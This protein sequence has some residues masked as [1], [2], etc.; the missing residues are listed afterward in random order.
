[1][2]AGIRRTVALLFALVPMGLVVA[3]PTAEALPPKLESA[4]ATNGL[5]TANWSL[6]PTVSTQFFEVGKYLEVNAYG[7][8]QCNRAPLPTRCGDEESN[9]VRFGVLAS[10][11][12]SLTPAD[13]T[14]PL[15]AGTYYIHIAGHD[16]VHTACPQVEFSQTR[17]VEIHQDGSATDHGVVAPGT[18]D[19]TL[20]PGAAGSGGGSAGGGGGGG[21]GAVAGDKIPP[22]TQLRYSRRQKLNKLRVRAR[23]SEPGTLT[24]RALVDVGGLLARIYNFRPVSRKVTGGV[25]ATLKPRLS[26]RHKRALR[27][28]LRKRKRLRAR[29]TVTATDRAGNRQTRHATIRLKRPRKRS[30]RGR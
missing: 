13:P 20:T 28:A 25:L 19:C 11:Q 2:S 18:G 3:A 5:L 26:K 14:P 16:R 10:N 17:Q 30:A 6:P 21:G 1:M 29:I 4:G 23:M 27:R 12:T 24:V 9:I 8:F 22:T 15:P 7:Y